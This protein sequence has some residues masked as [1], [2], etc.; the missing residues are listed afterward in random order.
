MYFTPVKV[1]SKLPAAS[2]MDWPMGDRLPN[3]PLPAEIDTASC[4]KPSTRR[5]EPAKG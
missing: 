5:S 3:A 1:T 4:T 2:T